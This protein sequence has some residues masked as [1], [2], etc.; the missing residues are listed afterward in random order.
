M[1]LIDPQ[2]YEAKP[3]AEI[4][5]SAIGALIMLKPLLLRF[6]CAESIA[7]RY[8]GATEKGA[9]RRVFIR[10]NKPFQRSFDATTAALSRER[11]PSTCPVE[12]FQRAEFLFV[13]IGERFPVSIPGIVIAAAALA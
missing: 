5:T 2:T 13:V 11:L 10:V 8:L 3:R 12:I 7:R 1:I 4:Y 6:V 9:W